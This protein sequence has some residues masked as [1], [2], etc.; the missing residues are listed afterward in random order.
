MLEVT[1]HSEAQEQNFPVRVI[2]V[3]PGISKNPT[4]RARAAERSNLGGPRPKSSS[5]IDN[6]NRQQNHLENDINRQMDPEVSMGEI[7]G[8]FKQ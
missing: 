6:Q 1:K 4:I 8:I 7:S 5:A 3:K 2:Y